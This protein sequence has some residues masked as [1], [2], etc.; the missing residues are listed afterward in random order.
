MLD[1]FGGTDQL[2]GS[3]LICRN[4]CLALG[5]IKMRLFIKFMPRLAPDLAATNEME[6]KRYGNRNVEII[7]SVCG[8]YF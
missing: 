8:V 2:E 5:A 1:F 4:F 7:Y 3:N 6:S